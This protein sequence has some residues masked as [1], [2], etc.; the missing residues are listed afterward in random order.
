MAKRRKELRAPKHPRVTR[1]ANAQLA[2]SVELLGRMIEAL[3]RQLDRATAT[4]RRARKATT[5]K[6]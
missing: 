4:R 3:Q 5:R 1:G 2:R 6:K